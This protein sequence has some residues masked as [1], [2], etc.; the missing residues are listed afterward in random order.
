MH[1]LAS[2]IFQFTLLFVRW[3]ANTRLGRAVVIVGFRYGAG[4]SGALASIN[5]H[6]LAKPNSLDRS[7]QQ[8]SVNY[9]WHYMKDAHNWHRSFI[10][11]HFWWGCHAQF[12]T[13]S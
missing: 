11:L 13:S 9:F 4:L 6:A 7:T 2:F 3:D 10:A 12:A 5:I 8:K 1:K